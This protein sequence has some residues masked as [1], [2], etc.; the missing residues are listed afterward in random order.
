MKRCKKCG[1]EKPLSEYHK[2]SSTKDRLQPN[3][4]ACERLRAVA[5]YAAN[6]ETVRAR[7]KERYRENREAVLA[8]HAEWRET[9]LDRHKEMQRD[10]YVRNAETLRKRYRDYNAIRRA[11]GYHWRNENP[12]RARELERERFRRLRQNPAFRLECNVRR[13]VSMSLRGEVKGGRTFDLLGYTPGE[14]RTHLERQFA[15]GMN[16]E[17]YGKW[18]LDHVLP[19]SSF[20]YATPQDEEF[21]RAWALTNLRPMWATENVR[22]GAKR[23]TLL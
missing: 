15:R 23:L 17:N 16:W 6:R 12:D 18:H 9:N 8:R 3:C 20:N 13:I 11:S 21:R 1:E 22:K 5:T 14:L 4:R 10:W 2:H 19:L 7:G